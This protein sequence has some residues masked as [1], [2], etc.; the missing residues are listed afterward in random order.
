M[1]SGLLFLFGVSGFVLIAYWAYWNDGIQAGDG[2]SGL[3]A[4]A[5]PASA[6][7]KT[8]PKWKKTM[9]SGT[10]RQKAPKKTSAAKPRWQQTF[11]YRD[12]R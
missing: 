4:M 10:S 7:Q 8:V 1:L 11:L 6:K 12:R 3:L 9:G 5:S 2:G